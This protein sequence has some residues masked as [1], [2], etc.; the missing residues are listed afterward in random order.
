M[1]NECRCDRGDDAVRASGGASG[2]GGVGG[3][4]WLLRRGCIALRMRARAAL[5]RGL[6]ERL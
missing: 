3:V 4:G 2:A 6:P 1:S 5:L